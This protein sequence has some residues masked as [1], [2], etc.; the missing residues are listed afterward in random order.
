MQTRPN[1]SY[2]AELLK[3]GL[4]PSPTQSLFQDL[5][6]IKFRVYSILLIYNDLKMAI[7]LTNS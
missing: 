1:E 7:S 4:N 2:D 5:I 3:R 6:Y